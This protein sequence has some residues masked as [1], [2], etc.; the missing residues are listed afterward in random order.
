[1]EDTSKVLGI[2]T[3]ALAVLM[4]ILYIAMLL[5]GLFIII[6]ARWIFEQTC[7]DLEDSP[8]QSQQIFSV[9]FLYFC[10]EIMFFINTNFTKLVISTLVIRF[11]KNFLP[12]LKPS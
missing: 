12:K 11:S 4:G 9:L 7:Q 3:W 8:I 1:M 5:L 10:N 2:P 6:C